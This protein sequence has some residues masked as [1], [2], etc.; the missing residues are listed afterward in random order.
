MTVTLSDSIIIRTQNHLVLKRTLNH[1]DKLAI[2][3]LFLQILT[4]KNTRIVQ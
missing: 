3:K 4:D 1:L 2:L